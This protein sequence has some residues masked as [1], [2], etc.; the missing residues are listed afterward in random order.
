MRNTPPQNVPLIKVIY[1]YQNG[2]KFE[3]T[4]QDVLNYQENIEGAS[5]LFNLHGGRFKEINWKKII[6]TKKNEKK[7][8]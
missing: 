3:I 2:E 8:D 7:K 4:G 1:E 6:I 5:D